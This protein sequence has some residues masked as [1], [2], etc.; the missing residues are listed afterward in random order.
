MSPWRIQRTSYARIGAFALTLLLVA[1]CT[2]GT[3][4][5]PDNAGL[6]AS[7]A[8]PSTAT[9]AASGVAQ[10]STGPVT[11]DQIKADFTYKDPLITPLA[12][13]YGSYLDDYV[14]VTVENG[15]NFAVK[16][17]V[18]SEIPNFTDQASDTVTV[19]AGAKSEI[20]QNPHLTT[21]A[22]DNLTSQQEGDLRVVV[23][24]LEAGQPRTILD[25]TVSA[26][27]TSRRDFPWTISG[28]DQATDY[29]L[30]SAMV[31]PTDPAVEQLIRK[32][33]NYDPSGAMVS[34]YETTG[35]S[36]GSVL[37]RMKDVWQAENN[38]Y[39]LTYISTT[40]TFN[41]DYQR[42]RLPSE[43]LN[44]AS[45]NCIELSLLYAAVAEALGMTPI[46][47]LIPGHAYFAVMVDDTG[48]SAYFIET[49]MIGGQY[50]FEQATAEGLSEWNDAQAHVS[51]GDKGYGSVNVAKARQ[52]GINPIPWH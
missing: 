26:T 9:P 51:A 28:M 43:V 8:H 46:I 14:I 50:T 5:Q 48:S 34:G 49:T 37:Q 47:I 39:H 16:V 29:E 41:A 42:I 13:L 20:R 11:V 38:D 3:P 22:I 6:L 30:I 35:D 18:T 40:E 27:I 7:A 25:E 10:S 2:T 23:N 33:A 17:T 45:G 32:A 1:G 15:N 31:T 52:D 24:Y 12:H 19:D 36:D 21:T 44:N 4:S